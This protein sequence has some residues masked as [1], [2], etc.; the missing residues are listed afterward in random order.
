MKYNSA[1]N[2]EKQA[3][4]ASLRESQHELCW[5]RK[6]SSVQIAASLKAMLHLGAMACY[7]PQ[8]LA[9]INILAPTMPDNTAV[10]IFDMKHLT[11]TNVRWL[12]KATSGNT[13][14]NLQLLRTF[15]PK[16]IHHLPIYTGNIYHYINH[17]AAQLIWLH[18]HRRTVCCDV[19]FADYIEEKSF[20]NAW[21]LQKE[22]EFGWIF[23]ITAFNSY[24]F[25]FLRAGKGLNVTN[26]EA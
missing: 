10:F 19:D 5:P 18:V 17:V 4:Y 26:L 1:I 16:S 12:S 14:C 23:R 20:F 13:I 15:F 22:K 8:L 21:I 9:S 3:L 25:T 24:T 6:S 11:F 7:R 2:C